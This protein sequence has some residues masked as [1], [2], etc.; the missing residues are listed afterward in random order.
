MFIDEDE[1]RSDLEEA[2]EEG[3]RDEAYED[4]YGS[5]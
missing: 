1:E 5:D 2:Y 3:R 4:D